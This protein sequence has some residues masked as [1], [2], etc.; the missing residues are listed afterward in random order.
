VDDEFAAFC[1][2]E[3][4]RL[5]AALDLF[6]GSAALAED[7]AQEA[8]ARAFTRWSRIRDLEAPGAYV[9]RIAMN[10]ATSAF[11]RRSAERRAH[12]RAGVGRDTGHEPDT[13]GGIA[14]RAALATLR[15]E[16]R[17]VIVLRYFLGHSVDETAALLGMPAGTVKTHTTRGIAALR[18]SLGV[19]ITTDELEVGRA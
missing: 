5:V 7:L 6:T 1:R 18:T 3:H 14:V 12:A 16:Q 11:R 19:S 13:A 9:H 2:R 8:L 10:L 17:K 15:P 4:G